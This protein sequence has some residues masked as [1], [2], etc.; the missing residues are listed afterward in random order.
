MC[1]II[2]LIAKAASQDGFEI[3]VS[4][5]TAKVAVGY[6]YLL[7]VTCITLTCVLDRLMFPITGY[8]LY[9]VEMEALLTPQY[10]P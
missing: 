3:M 8:Y 4:Q 6:R 5:Q 10:T 2:I 9:V 7:I 1:L